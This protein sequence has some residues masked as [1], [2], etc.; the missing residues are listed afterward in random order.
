MR[1][2]QVRDLFRSLFLNYI[3][4]INNDLSVIGKSI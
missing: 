2:L 1:F 3:I 4:V